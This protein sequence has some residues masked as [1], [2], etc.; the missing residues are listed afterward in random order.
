MAGRGNSVD[1]PAVAQP[2]AP[3]GAQAQLPQTE[4]PQPAGLAPVLRP[5]VLL[6]PSAAYPGDAGEM[7][8]DRSSLTPEIRTVVAQG[9]V[10]LRILVRADGTVGD[11]DVAESSGHSV[12][13]A[14]AIQ[15]SSRWRF[16][17]ATRDGEPIEAWVLVPVR[18]VVP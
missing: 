12:L 2:S 13:D 9:R 14:S 15:A 17:P 16:Q 3:P 6:T 5:P 11:V 7:T 4:A 18:F 1:P 10:V 8:I